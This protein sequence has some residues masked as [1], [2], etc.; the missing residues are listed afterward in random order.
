MQSNDL[1]DLMVATKE[2]APPAVRARV[3]RL[4]AKSAAQAVIFR[5]L[6]N[7]I[8]EPF[9]LVAG[10]GIK[11]VV[12]AQNP[13]LTERLDAAAD[14]IGKLDAQGV[15]QINGWRIVRRNSVM[16]QAG[17]VVYDCLAVRIA[18]GPLAQ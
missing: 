9:H 5:D 16:Y 2:S 15:C 13:A 3:I 11:P 17:R 7:L 6:S 12:L 8:V 18:E 1:L 10:P 4:Q 14:L